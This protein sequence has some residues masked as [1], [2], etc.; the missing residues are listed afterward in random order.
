MAK[1][2]YH[3]PNVTLRK[4]AAILATISSLTYAVLPWRLFSRAIACDLAKLR[5]SVGGRWDAKVILTKESYEELT[6]WINV[7]RENL[8]RPIIDPPVSF[9][10]RSDDGGGLSFVG[11]GS[12]H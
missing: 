6:Y 10:T 3:S 2:L 11:H 4:I 8:K 12:H 1:D 7:I 9:R 5:K